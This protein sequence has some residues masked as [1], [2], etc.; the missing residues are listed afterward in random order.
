MPRI[1][2]P[3]LSDIEQFLLFDNHTAYPLDFSYRL[4]FDRQ[5]NI[6]ALTDCFNR[7]IELHPLLCA[8]VERRGRRWY[9]K[10][11][12]T[13]SQ[14]VIDQ[15]NGA[16]SFRLPINLARENGVRLVVTESSQGTCLVFHFHHTATDGLGAMGLISDVLQMYD[17]TDLQPCSRDPEWLK[18]RHKCGYPKDS[19]SNYVR[20]HARAIK[21]AAQFANAKICPLVQHQPDRKTARTKDDCARHMSHRFT[22]TETRA[23]RSFAAEN[24]VSLNTLLIRDAFVAFDAVRQTFDGYDPNGN[25]RIAIPGDL[26]STRSN[27]GF[28]AANFFSMIFPHKN[29]EQIAEQDRLLAVIHEEVKSARND[30]FLAIFRLSLK[31]L[32]RIPGRLQREVNLN[33]C[34]ATILLTNVGSALTEMARSGD[35]RVVVD[36]AILQSIELVA[37]IRPFQTIA[38][39]T[40]EYAGRQ[41]VTFTYDPRIHTRCQADE[42][43]ETYI[44]QLVTRVESQMAKS[45]EQ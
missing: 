41:T 7:A 6:E 25:I 18:H 36:G 27:V 17:G 11:Q 3:Q 44:K 8:I 37:P 4:Q 23:L 33:K 12:S 22:E 39:S 21:L 15:G 9:W 14:V 2:A 16:D 31:I 32:R 5:L 1:P 30:Y 26:R 40:I 20:K 34:H 42:I 45:A 13:V 35:S 38:V 24:K 43:L 19:V 10:L 28:P 29:A